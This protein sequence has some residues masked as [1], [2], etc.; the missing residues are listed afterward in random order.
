[1]TQANQKISIILLLLKQVMCSYECNV[2]LK[3]LT[4]ELNKYFSFHFGQWEETVCFPGK[5]PEN[6]YI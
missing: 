5:C 1:M 4:V 6:T 3:I 2:L